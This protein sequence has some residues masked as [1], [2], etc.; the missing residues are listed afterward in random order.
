MHLQ[1][2]PALP[3]YPISEWISVMLSWCLLYSVF[4]SCCWGSS[5]Q[6]PTP[7]HGDTNTNRNSLDYYMLGWFI[8]ILRFGIFLYEDVMSGWALSSI[9]PF[10]TCTHKGVWWLLLDLCTVKLASTSVEKIVPVLLWS[11]I[12]IH[13]SWTIYINYNTFGFPLLN[14]LNFNPSSLLWVKKKT[15]LYVN[16]LKIRLIETTDSTVLMEVWFF[17]SGGGEGG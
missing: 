8:L 17:V 15:K 10:C 5:L 12:L 2:T 11:E 4:G 7:A 3:L 1:A 16:H 9:R 6:K 14:M 13:F